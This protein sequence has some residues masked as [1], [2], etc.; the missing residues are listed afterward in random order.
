MNDF[1][2]LPVYPFVS[3][4]EEDSTTSSD[5]TVDASVAGICAEPVPVSGEPF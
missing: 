5:G 1:V 2:R 3:Q 4:D